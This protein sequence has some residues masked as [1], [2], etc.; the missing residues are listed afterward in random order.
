MDIDH[1]NISIWDYNVSK[2]GLEKTRD[3]VAPTGCSEHQSG[4]AIDIASLR[5]GYILT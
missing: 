3:R 5:Y 4:L 1:L 2:M